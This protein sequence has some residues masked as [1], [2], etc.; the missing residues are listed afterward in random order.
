MAIRDVECFQVLQI[1]FLAASQAA[2]DMAAQLSEMH[3]VFE[4]TIR[5]AFALPLDQLSVASRARCEAH[6]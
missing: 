6:W 4:E 5:T 2:L 1:H 3:A